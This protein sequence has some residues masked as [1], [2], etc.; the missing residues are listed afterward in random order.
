MAETHKGAC[1][2]GA[3][4]IEATGHPVEMGY[5]HCTSCRSY[6][7]APLNAYTLWT[8]ES[9]RV[10]RGAKFL[11][12][13]NKVGFSNRQHCTRCGGHVL[14]DHPA[15]GFVDLYASILPTLAF[16][17]TVHL[18]YSETILPMRDGLPKLKDFPKE[19]GGSGEVIPE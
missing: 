3:V 4:E 9:V 13:F 10:I 12:G 15:I 8:K 17:P 2:C 19:A 6:S 11:A 18:N 16:R 7:G 1:F 5:C 14:V